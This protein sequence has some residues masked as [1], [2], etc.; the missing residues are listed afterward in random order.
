[1]AQTHYFW[2]S[3]QSIFIDKLNLVQPKHH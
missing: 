3:R 1:L 2:E